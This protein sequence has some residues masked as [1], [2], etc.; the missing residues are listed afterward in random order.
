MTGAVAKTSLNVVA[1][2]AT[3]V[4]LS[5]ERQRKSM[6]AK[7]SER[8]AAEKRV[9]AIFTQ[10]F[11][12]E[13]CGNFMDEV[14]SRFDTAGMAEVLEEDNLAASIDVVPI[15][16]PQELVSKAFDLLMSKLNDNSYSV[17]S[18]INNWA[19]NKKLVDHKDV[20][21]TRKWLVHLL[22]NVYDLI[23][24]LVG[25]S[26]LCISGDATQSGDHVY[27][28]ARLLKMDRVQHSFEELINDFSKAI[29]KKN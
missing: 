24:E 7:R 10:E 6:Q 9:A 29:L 13:Y 23:N 11:V 16:T 20:A 25:E 28:A 22:G 19:A 5:R 8:R 15:V 3:R 2:R 1:N 18:G 14:S 17:I 12:D 4:G 27:L 21:A 26:D